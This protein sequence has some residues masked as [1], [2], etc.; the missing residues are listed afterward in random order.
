MK[1]THFTRILLI[2]L[3]VLLTALSVSGCGVTL[4]PGENG[5][6]DKENEVSYVHA[7]TVYEA[8]ALVKEYG[9]L[10][11]T[12]QETHTLYTVPGMEPTEMLAT[13]DGNILHASDYSMPTLLQMA[14]TILRICADNMEIK[15]MEDAVTVAKIANQYAG[16]E[17]IAYPGITPLR[18][19]KARF[20]SVIYPG[21]FYTLTYVEYS[22]DLEIDG[23]NYGRYFLYDAFDKRFIPI[24]DTIH[25]SMGLS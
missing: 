10:D 24:D 25:T 18:S 2:T 9:K 12:N 5:L 1:A 16:G 13:E 22:Q 15:R 6:Y 3:S 7:S 11:V 17:S 14:P 4:K 23:E 19:Y 20:E 21:F 8:I